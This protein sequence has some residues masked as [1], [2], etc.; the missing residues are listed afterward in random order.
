MDIER[1]HR[2][3]TRSPLEEA[4]V[5]PPLW[6]WCAP[7][8]SLVA[9]AVRLVTP[10]RSRLLRSGQRAKMSRRGPAACE[11]GVAEAERVS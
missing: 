2:A 10:L 5:V 4:T 9:E 7:S 11:W 6:L 1:G 8:Q 3:W